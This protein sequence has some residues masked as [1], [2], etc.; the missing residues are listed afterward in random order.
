MLIALLSD[1]NKE[2]PLRKLLGTRQ[3]SPM[4]GVFFSGFKARFSQYDSIYEP[5]IGVPTLHVMGENDQL[6]SRVRTCR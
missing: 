5:G 1:K 6:V 4:A 3:G 2:H